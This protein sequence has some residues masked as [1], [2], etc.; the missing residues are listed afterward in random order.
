MLGDDK[1]KVSVQSAQI[2][3]V[4]SRFGYIMRRKRNRARPRECTHVLPDSC[5]PN[6]VEKRSE[7]LRRNLQHSRANRQEAPFGSFRPPYTSKRHA[8]SAAIAPYSDSFGIGVLRTSDVWLACFGVLWVL[9]RG[10]ADF[11]E[12][13][14]YGVDPRPSDDT[15]CVSQPATSRRSLLT[16]RLCKG[17]PTLTSQ[18]SLVAGYTAW[19]GAIRP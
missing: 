10:Y 18:T 16:A 11:H 13:V 7:K 12:K 9:D 3:P 2:C 5:S 14:P 15:L 8:R 19:S 4:C 17:T 6:L 1:C